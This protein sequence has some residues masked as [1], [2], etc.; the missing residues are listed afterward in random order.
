MNATT[1]LGVLV[2]AAAIVF[3]LLT[4]PAGRK[5]AERLGLPQLGAAR[6]GRV[7]KEDRDYLLRVCGGDAAEVERRLTAERERF[8]D[9]SEPEIYR[10]AIRTHMQSRRDDA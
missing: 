4:M 9:L 10:R 7:P 5:V 6:A 8:S 2:A 1:L 3:I